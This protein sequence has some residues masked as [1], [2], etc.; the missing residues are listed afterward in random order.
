MKKPSVWINDI[1]TSFA[2]SD[3]CP[4]CD[5]EENGHYIEAIIE[6]LDKEWQERRGDSGVQTNVKCEDCN[7]QVGLIVGGNGYC[8]CGGKYVKM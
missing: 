2:F 7:S 6:Y 4:A 3:H 5:C 8:S 1:A